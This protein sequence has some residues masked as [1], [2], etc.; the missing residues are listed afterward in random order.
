MTTKE[1]ASPSLFS[2]TYGEDTKLPLAIHGARFHVTAAC[3]QRLALVSAHLTVC[4]TEVASDIEASL[5]F[6]LPDSDATVCGFSV[7][8]DSAIAVAKEVAKEVAYK[9]REKGRAVATAANVSGAV[10]ETTV[11]PLPHLIPV[12][13]AIQTVC[14]LDEAADGSMTLHLPLIFSA[15]VADITVTSSAEDGSSGHHNLTSGAST[16]PEGLHVTFNTPPAGAIASALH[17]SSFVWS[18]CVPKAM[19]DA[20]FAAQPSQTSEEAAEAYPVATPPAHLGLIV[21]V[22]RSAAPMTEARLKLLDAIGS[23]FASVGRDVVVTVWAASRRATCLGEQLSVAEAKMKIEATRCDGGT[24]LSLLTGLLGGAHALGCEAVVLCT[25]GVNN[26]LAKQLPDLTATPGT[27]ALPVHIPLPPSGVNANLNVLRWLA[28]QTGGSASVGLDSPSEFA[29]VVSGAAA[30]TTLVKLTTDLS[31]DV[32]AFEDETFVTT[33]DFRLAA[34]SVAAGADGALR[35]SGSCD[36]AARPPPTAMTLT[37]KRGTATAT[38]TLPIP[39]P[40][41][42]AAAAAAETAEAATAAGV[43]TEELEAGAGEASRTSLG[44]LLQVQHALLSLRQLQLEQYDPSQAKQQATELA[45]AVGIASEHTSLLKLS[46]PEQFADHNLE[47][48]PGH[49]AHAK[50]KELVA[51]RAKDK[52]ARDE[53]AKQKTQQKLASL[54]KPM[55]ARY[56]EMVSDKSHAWGRVTPGRPGAGGGGDLFGATRRRGCGGGCGGGGGGGGGGS[57]SRNRSRPSTGGGAPVYRGSGGSL[58]AGCRDVCADDEPLASCLLARRGCA[59]DS[60][61]DGSDDGSDDYG[62]APARSSSPRAATEELCVA[63]S[64]CA[65]EGFDDESA[66]M[67]V[68]TEVA[69]VGATVDLFGGAPPP[70]APAPLAQ[71]QQQQMAPPPAPPPPSEPFGAFS[72]FGEAPLPPRCAACPSATAVDFDP[73]FSTEMDVMEEEEERTAQLEARVETTIRAMSENINSALERSETLDQL[74]A[75]SSSLSCSAASFQRCARP[76]APSLGSALSGLADSASRLLSPRTERGGG[77]GG[78]GDNLLAAI[79]GGMHPLAKSKPNKPQ[80]NKFEGL[81]AWCAAIGEVYEASGVE[82][83]LA[84]LDAYIARTP[85]AEQKPSTFVMASEVLHACGAD[86]EVCADVLFNVLEAKLPDTQVCRVVAYHLLSFGRLDDALRLL[87]LVREMLAPAEPHSYT[88]LAFVRF[89]KLRALCAESATGAPPAATVRAEMAKVIADLAKVLTSTEWADRFREIEW[90]ALILLSW[91]VA[92]AEHALGGGE[93]SLCAEASLW[94]EAELPAKDYRLGGAAGPK[95]DCFVW[96]GWDTDH[97][98][99][100]LHVKEPTG[101]EVYYSHNRSASTGAR[102]SR[103][104]TQGYGP[105]V[106][107]LPRAPKG[108]YKVD[109]KYY[110]SHQHTAATGTTSAVLW[111]IKSMGDFGKEEVQFK[112]VRLGR[113]KERQ[114]VLTIDV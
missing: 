18:G 72:P 112:S 16:M 93:A 100:D 84:A 92:W 28:H 97:T 37:I 89:H 54:V 36:P 11:F 56:H 43:T 81:D 98:D 61:S 27:A 70:P 3:G 103:D 49:A 74:A 113:N 69:E 40:T 104:F 38:I 76:S 52:E 77:G 60:G 5:K 87:E 109:A 31:A 14:K 78:G 13:V 58:A 12:E 35:L 29:D 2:L 82:A 46:M 94:P 71:Q 53:A 7:G 33:P 110:A 41:A 51:Q 86:A 17:A 45:C 57:G 64:L 44:R 75:Q 106:Y 111:S 34:L 8:A 47:C 65:D 42:E 48:P 24:D 23:S 99:I 88:D 59:A 96:L 1:S 108:E 55:T 25:D 101:E 26:L 9:E 79:R 6:P 85:G 21:D 95:L 15:P 114:Q 102:V 80:P 19:I 91:A 20:A 73:E 4:N 10:W 63:R 105:E 62:A 50:W 68:E 83:A 90:P 67:E 107:T 30:Q 22:S 39:P 32:D 66:M